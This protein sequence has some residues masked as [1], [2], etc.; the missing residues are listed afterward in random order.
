MGCACATTSS[1]EGRR[2]YCDLTGWYGKV[3][4][5][6]A[7]LSPGPRW[8]AGAEG[9]CA[10]GCGLGAVDGSPACVEVGDFARAWKELAKD[11]AKFG[12]VEC[13]KVLMEAGANIEA[14]N[15]VSRTPHAPRPPLSSRARA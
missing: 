12:K 3:V 15:K 10:A 6:N 2:G 5:E 14:T 4:R 9:G 13:V 1:N 7:T 11:A 8:A